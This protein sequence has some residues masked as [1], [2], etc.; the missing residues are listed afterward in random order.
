MSDS[1][2]PHGLQPTRL[3]CLWDSPA[4]NTG[5]GCHSFLQGELPDP[6]MEPGSPALAGCFF[7]VW[8][9]DKGSFLSSDW[10]GLLL[11]VVTLE[12][13]FLGI[14]IFL[15]PRT[16]EAN[17]FNSI[18]WVVLLYNF[19]SWVRLSYFWLCCVFLLCHYDMFW[20]GGRMKQLTFK[21]EF[22]LS[23][24]KSLRLQSGKNESKSFDIV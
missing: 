17:T 21:Y 5:V 4:K 9:T 24:P 13:W 6:G 19:W 7:N 18:C 14:W 23:Q 16:Q 20:K 3:L 8:A 2:W 22:I 10:Q 12:Y 11:D 15:L 1:L